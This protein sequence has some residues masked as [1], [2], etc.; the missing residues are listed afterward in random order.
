MKK[1][2]KA[3]LL[4]TARELIRVLS[5]TEEDKVTPITVE[6]NETEEGLEAFIKEAIKLIAPT[7][8]FEP[9]FQVII[10]EFEPKLYPKAKVEEVSGDD[11]AGAGD[12]PDDL[13]TQ[14]NAT[15]RLKDL[16]E[17]CKANDEFKSIRGKLGSYKSFDDLRDAMITVL[18]TPQKAADKL[19]EKNIASK[20]VNEVKHEAKMDVVKP[21]ASKAPEKKAEPV[22]PAAA[23][24]PAPADKLEV[25]KYSRVDS[26][27][28]AIKKHKGFKD[29]EQ[30]AAKANELYVAAG[31]TDNVKESKNIMKY[32]LPALIAFDIEVPEA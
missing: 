5:L 19:H 28:D 29:R 3:Q 25:V 7:D 2:T 1:L 18:E 8:P 21:A 10:H 23:K 6:D 15:E 11:G 12:S 20:E 24:K 31:G 13:I 27:C 22:K 32:V 26:I 9:K 16:K 30:L 17:M 4:E 14:I